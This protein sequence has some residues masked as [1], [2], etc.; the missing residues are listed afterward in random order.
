[1]N[2]QT[3]EVDKKVKSEPDKMK[4][5]KTPESKLN[6]KKQKTPRKETKAESSSPVYCEFAVS[7]LLQTH[8]LNNDPSD[9]KTQVWGCEFEPDSERKGNRCFVHSKAHFIVLMEAF[10]YFG[11]SC[12]NQ[13]VAE[14]F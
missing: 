12:T 14:G 6:K 2:G 9:R 1:M 3:E 4:S 7:H 10:D 8:S 13:Q 11:T 5:I